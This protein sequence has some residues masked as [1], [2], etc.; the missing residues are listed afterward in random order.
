MCVVLRRANSVALY[1]NTHRN[2]SYRVAATCSL[3]TLSA[4]MGIAVMAIADVLE[5]EG[6]RLDQY[7]DSV[8]AGLQGATRV[9]ALDVAELKANQ[10]VLIVDVI[11]EHPKPDNLPQGQLWFPVPHLGVAG[12][13]WLPDVGYGVLSQVTEN[14]FKNHLS[15]ATTGN[16]DH[17]VV[18]Y[19]R[20]DCWMS[21]NAAKR[22]MSY[23][24]RNIFWFADG[25]EDWLFEDLPT[26]VLTPAEGVRH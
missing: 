14:Y 2:W 16:F 11:P 5:P 10:Q 26:Q 6:Y 17:P 23:G 20:I 24:Y 3:M 13:L 7:D 25:M 1:L 4:L 18:F 22:A 8:P 9:S 21:W 12:A 15:N 19:C